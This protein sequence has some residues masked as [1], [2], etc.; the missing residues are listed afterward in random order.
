ML[1]LAH[2]LW[3]YRYE[4]TLAVQLLAAIRKNAR[5]A[6]QEYIRRQIKRKLKR[7]LVIVSAEV[8]LLL[9]SYCLTSYSHSLFSAIV[10][11]MILWGITLYNL[12][13]LLL[14]TIPELRQVHRQLRGKVGYTLK[15]FLQISVT[16]ELLQ[17]NV[18]FLVVC[19]MLGISTRTYISRNFSYVDPWRK[20][21]KQY[22]KVTAGEKIQNRKRSN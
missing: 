6:T 10:S 3:R 21:G 4:I 19:L 14:H 20:L 17:L 9:L 15:Y 13:E 11:S 5:E 1:G 2:L 7:Q 8:S 16:T 22:A 18:V 12:S